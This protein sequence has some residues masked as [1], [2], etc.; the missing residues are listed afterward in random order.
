[1]STAEATILAQE[2]EDRAGGG[3][4]AGHVDTMVTV[5]QSLVDMRHR[6]A[7][8]AAEILELQ[9]SIR[10]VLYL[11]GHSSRWLGC[12]SSSLLSP[13][14]ALS[15]FLFSLSYQIIII[16]TMTFL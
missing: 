7:V 11:R 1:V 16:L 10:Y 2:I 15:P 8:D 6:G 12:K 9:V 5:A 14:L 4:A 13:G 3:I